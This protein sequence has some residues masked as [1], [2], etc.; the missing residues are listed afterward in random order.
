MPS[1]WFYA[2]E[3]QQ[4]GP[5]SSEEIKALAAEGQIAGDHLVWKN[6]MA[7]WLPASR[8]KGLLPDSAKP[9]PALAVP[10]APPPAPNRLLSYAGSGVAAPNGPIAAPPAAVVHT[11]SDLPPKWR[12]PGMP[13]VYLVLITQGANIE[14]AFDVSPAMEQIAIGFAKKLGKKYDV[15]IVSAVPAEGPYALVRLV[16]VDEGNRFLR[17]FLTLFA[18]K[19]V[20]EVEGTTRSITAK[21]TPYAHKHKGTGG[22]GGGSGISL[23]KASG[24]YLGKKIAKQVL[25]K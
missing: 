9:A 25:K 3:G 14:A 13:A 1:S 20:L 7:E 19:T 11:P 24:M 15:Q 4:F 23:L 21:T 8:I 22:I 2:K 18:G 12:H 16:N 10:I 6:G 5:H 17:Y